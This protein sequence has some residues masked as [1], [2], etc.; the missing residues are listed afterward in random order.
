MK[1]KLTVLL[2]V[3]LAGCAAMGKIESGEQ[4]VSDQLVVS[5]D[6]PWNQF[7]R[8]VDVPTWTVEGLA[9]DQLR[10]FI[11]IKDGDPIAKRPKGASE[12]RPLTFHSTM[13]A[14]EV[15]ALFQGLYTQDGSTFT[16]DGIEPVTFIGESGFKYT[17]TVLRRSDDVRLSG[18]GYGAVHNGELTVIDYSA[19]RLGFFPRYKDQ[20]ERMSLG[21]HLRS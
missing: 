12:Q 9:V 10:F 20:I 14:H 17:Y 5:L 21:A 19:P 1:R 16:L 7:N 6:G 15:V 3:T 4:V 13:K 8:G 18:V 2:C 11:G